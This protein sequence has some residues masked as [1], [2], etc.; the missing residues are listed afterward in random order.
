[1]NAVWQR[2][3]VTRNAPTLTDL[4]NVHAAQDT[5]LN[6]TKQH[7]QVCL[8]VFLVKVILYSSPCYI[9]TGAY[10]LL[11]W[12]QAAQYL[13]N[14][15]YIFHLEVQLLFWRKLS[16]VAIVIQCCQWFNDKSIYKRLCYVCR[17]INTNCVLQHILKGF[18]DSGF[19]H[20]VLQSVICQITV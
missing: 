14:V 12:C 7:V 15:C 18:S 13:K 9:D 16:S 2:L 4:S 19:G 10:P 11:S 1:M 5:L 6:R 17:K 20:I 8:M 3:H